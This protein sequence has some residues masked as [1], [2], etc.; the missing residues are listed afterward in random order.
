MSR[1]KCP[2]SRRRWP[3][4]DWVRTASRDA[5]APRAG[6]RRRAPTGHDD[7]LTD[8][9]ALKACPIQFD[10]HVRLDSRLCVCH[11][12]DNAK[13]GPPR[14]NS[15]ALS[16]GGREDLYGTTL[17]RCSSQTAK[18]AKLNRIRVC[19]DQP[20][21]AVNTDCVIDNAFRL[22]VRSIL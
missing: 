7:R 20:Q 18:T 13:S 6:G 11:T 5:L 21:L 1:G 15:I 10:G 22:L 8:L 4:V 9:D 16:V 14:Q 3:A 2:F 12:A 19:R 17:Q